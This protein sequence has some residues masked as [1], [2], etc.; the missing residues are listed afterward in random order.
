MSAASFR[1]L[2]NLAAL[3]FGVLPFLL[4]PVALA[5]TLTAQEGVPAPPGLVPEQMW[6][7]PTAAD[8]QK[9]VLIQWQR[10]WDDA[11]RLSK[12][13]K[14][15]I[16]VCVNMDGEIASEHYAGIR[17]RDPE[18]TRFYEPYICVIASVYRHN[19]RD[20]DDQGR[21]IPCPRLGDCTCGEHIAMEPI[22]FEKFLD[23]KRI[24]P[25]HIMV[26]L[27][28]KK[29]YDVFYTWDTAS[30][31]KA[32]DDGIKNRAIQA[33]PIVKGDRSILEKV[34]SADSRDRTEVEH[35]YTSGTAEQ[36][37]SLLQAALSLGEQAPIELLRLGAY[38]LDTDLNKQARQGM[39][40]AK[41]PG[42]VDLI[43][44][45]LRAPLEANERHEL[46]EAL[47]KFADTSMKAR[48]F[49]NAHRGFEQES[50]VINTARW[51]SVLEG[52]A[53]QG[54]Y[55]AE[56][57]AK[58]GSERDAAIAAQPRSPE[59]RLDVAE[60][61]LLQALSTVAG[62]GPGGS[63]Q[64]QQYR[65]MLFQDAERTAHSA[66]ALGASGWRL[67]AILC[68]CAR[69]RGS[70]HEA[71]D[72]AISAAPNLPPE[73]PGQLAMEVLALFAAARQE[74]I[75]TAVREKKDFPPQWTTDV[76]A[77]Y[78]VLE[79]HPL[80]TDAHFA[81]HYDFL[82]FF[83]TPEA[84]AVLDRGIERFPAS[85][86][87]HERLRSRLLAQ[88]DPA[89]LEAEYERRVAAA[90]SSQS[91]SSPTMPWFAGYA[92]LCAAEAHRRTHH[93]DLAVA[94]YQR[95]I[96]H[97]EH[98]QKA[99]GNTDGVHYIA[100]AHAGIA[101]TQLLAGDLNATF[102]SLQTVFQLAPRAAASVD[103]LGTTAM[104]TAEMLRGRA[105][106]EKQD[107]LLKKIDAAIAAL[108]PEAHELPE[109]EQNSRPANRRRRG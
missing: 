74:G 69:E 36:R 39:T 19:P 31:F 68:L 35:A 10:T 3:A 23:G 17:Y 48:T 2:P 87:L 30:V 22:V 88:Q 53:Y 90:G 47:G 108:P 81:Y 54:A 41:D 101:R 95:G 65:R 107:E 52:A 8:W 15:P 12:E 83:G 104:Q 63:R 84:D 37:R 28:G 60:T 109:Y 55:S 40:K 56:D 21:R 94:A 89:A 33:P 7:A 105:L 42:T 103:G 5:T 34:A 4:A 51:Q 57:L 64:A 66:I 71:Y 11:V 20:Y 67:D 38:G 32:I 72:L 27:D 14:R 1:R 59:A 25:R 29:T 100:M 79:R 44:D 77:A 9:P 75:V 82:H 13:T 62:T 76:H 26:E 49:A 96:A 80:G 93:N 78:A 73:A 86:M 45:T 50:T 85:P 16:L 46:V 43:A 18:I 91:G 6:P 97:F 98:Y 106:T 70:I 58:K 24:S 61:N 92:S 102:A 99:T